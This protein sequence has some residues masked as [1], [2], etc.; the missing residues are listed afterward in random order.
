MAAE[1]YNFS[2]S[3]LSPLNGTGHVIALQ[4]YAT[5]PFDG[6]GFHSPT[7]TSTE[8]YF[9]DYYLYKWTESY[10]DTLDGKPVVTDYYEDWKDG[11]C[12]E[13]R[14]DELPD[15]EYLLVAQYGS[16]EPLDNSGVWYIGEEYPGT[17]S[18]LDDE[19]F[20]DASICTT[21]FYTKTPQNIYGP[22]SDSGLE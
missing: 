21:I 20:Y 2:E 8:N 11:I 10:Y 4:F 18:Y 7:W 5:A 16:N 15:G 13:M 1:L 19:I 3:L 22:L 17:R 14:F 6:I 9:V 12:V